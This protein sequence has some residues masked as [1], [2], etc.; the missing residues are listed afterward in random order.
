MGESGEVEAA[1]R[2]DRAAYRH[3]PAHEEEQ[4]RIAKLVWWDAVTGKIE[5]FPESADVFH[6]HP[7]GLVGNFF[8]KISAKLMLGCFAKCGHL[9]LCPTLNFK[10]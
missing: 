9:R 7:V 3:D 5:G 1:V 10:N 4:K 8:S 2:V 6:I